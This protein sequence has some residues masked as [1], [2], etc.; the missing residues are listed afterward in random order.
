M[1][2]VNKTVDNDAME[3]EVTLVTPDVAEEVGV[4]AMIVAW[5]V[6]VVVPDEIVMTVT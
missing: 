5:T 4:L 1:L 2:E 6:V 3:E